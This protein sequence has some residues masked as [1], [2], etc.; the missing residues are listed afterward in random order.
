MYLFT[1]LYSLFLNKY[2]LLGAAHTTQ[3]NYSTRYPSLLTGIPLHT[4]IS[5]FLPT[6]SRAS[7]LSFI[8][9]EIISC[10]GMTTIAALN[11]ALIVSPCQDPTP[12]GLAGRF[13]AYNYMTSHTVFTHCWFIDTVYTF[14]VFKQGNSISTVICKKKLVFQ[15]KP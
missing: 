15:W 13:D 6:F 5:P 11:D 1:F 14:T 10:L 12:L 3:L 8:R 9:V 2:N 4:T 7:N